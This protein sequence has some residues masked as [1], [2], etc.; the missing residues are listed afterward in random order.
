MC[1]L[2]LGLCCNHLSY[3]LTVG[4]EIRCVRLAMSKSVGLA[5]RYKVGA[6]GSEIGYI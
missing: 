6:C 2:G 4:C 5:T 1:V 3:D